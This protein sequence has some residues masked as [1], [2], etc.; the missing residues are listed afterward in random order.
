[1]RHL[2][3]A[4]AGFLA[5]L[6]VPASAADPM[7]ELPM[8]AP[9]FD[10]TGYYAGMQAGYGWG[11]SDIEGT[12]GTPF[13]ASPDID[14]GFIGAHVAGLWQFNQVVLGGV[15]ELNYAPIA[16]AVEI[17][18]GNSIGTG[19]QW[20]G[21]VSAKAGFA[22]DRVLVY[23][24]GGVAFAGIETSQDSIET[25]ARTHTNVGWTLGAGVD[26]ALTDQFV[27]GAQYRYYDFGSEHYDG[28]DTFLDRKQD[29]KLNAVSLNL[30]YKF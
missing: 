22:V 10:W 19:I 21:S 23:G 18:P 20:F 13:S 8:T 28:T 2:T 3:L 7:G 4:T 14:G 25:F 11:I 27:V 16:G 29:V 9:G 5:A 1:M 30:S 26:Y 6:V 24:T 15:A 12:S 17:G